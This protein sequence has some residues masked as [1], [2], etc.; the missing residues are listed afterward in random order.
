[1]K[2]LIFLVFFILG[3]SNKEISVEIPQKPKVISNEIRKIKIN[4]FKNDTIELRKAVIN[5]MENINRFFHYFEIN[6]KNPTS[7]LNADVN[8]KHYEK[9]YIKKLKIFYKTS[10]CKFYLYSCKSINGVFFCKDIPSTI[11]SLGEFE[12]IKKQA[13][14][15][16]N[17]ILYKNTIYKVVKKCKPLYKNVLCQK[18]FLALKTDVD[19]KNKSNISIF[20]NS[21]NFEKNEDSCKN[22][23]NYEGI[24]IYKLPSLKL[25]I[26]QLKQKTAKAI[27]YDIAPHYVIKTLE[28]L[29]DLD[30]KL[31]YKDEE[32]FKKA[33]SLIDNKPY[34]ALQILSKLHKKYPNSEVITYNLA[35][36]L[37]KN[38]YYKNAFD[39]VIGCKLKECQKLR[40]LL[41]EVYE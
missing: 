36:V 7:F 41:S 35:V 26:E 15:N 24:K 21:Y 13:Y 29:E 9:N 27:V 16:S 2:W 28:I 34:I 11:L 18:R 6:P 23:E 33:I 10:P 31:N 22:L 5:E 20:Q 25:S 17:Y 37:I 3:C 32:E 8:F 40:S 38:G 19:I 39:L 1:M 12:K 4:K 30:I 14:K